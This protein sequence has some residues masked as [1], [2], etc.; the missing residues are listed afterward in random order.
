ME[1]LT[2]TQDEKKTAIGL[3]RK[4]RASVG[5]LVSRDDEL[6]VFK[7]LKAAINGDSVVRDVFGLNPV[8]SKFADG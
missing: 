1:R 3:A 7:Y 5:G 2:F 4:L 6:N 8:V